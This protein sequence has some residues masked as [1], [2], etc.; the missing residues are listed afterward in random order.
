LTTITGKGQVTM[1]KEVRKSPE[2]QASDKITPQQY[3]S[4]KRINWDY[5]IPIKD[6]F[7]VVKGERLRAGFWTRDKL[8]VRMLEK[9]SWYELLDFFSP[10]FLA[11]KLAPLFLNQLHNPEKRAK[12]ERLGK[13][14]RGEPVSFTR[15]GAENLTAIRNTLFS[16]RW[17]ST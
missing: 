17:Y 9:M 12:Y 7:A 16:N 5:N 6:L 13:I 4:L 14:L 11:E 8:L 10:E 1:S 2:R 15:W 3:R